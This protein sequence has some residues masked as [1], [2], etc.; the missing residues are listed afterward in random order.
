MNVATVNPKPGTRNPKRSYE[1]TTGKTV[2]WHD[3]VSERKFR[4]F[5][6]IGRNLVTQ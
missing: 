6:V 1:G 4:K 2:G 3:R 5:L